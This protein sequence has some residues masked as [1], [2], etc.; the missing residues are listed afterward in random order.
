M[1]LAAAASYD[2]KSTSSQMMDSHIVTV[3]ELRSMVS[4]D[5]DDNFPVTPNSKHLCNQYLEGMSTKDQEALLTHV[6]NMSKHSF[7]C[8]IHYKEVVHETLHM[9]YLYRGWLLEMSRRLNIFDKSLH[10][11]TDLK[12]GKAEQELQ[13]LVHVLVGQMEP[14][15]AVA[16]HQDPGV[17]LEYLTAARDGTRRA[18]D[19]ADAEIAI[20]KQFPIGDSDDKLEVIRVMAVP[21]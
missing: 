10:H 11:E 20:L 18:L 17:H 6:K 16:T 7:H 2:E 9:E 21:V 14:L 3:P 19:N 8:T 15:H 5:E 13:W 4:E 12:L 1:D